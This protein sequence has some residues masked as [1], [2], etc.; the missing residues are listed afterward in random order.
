MFLG[1]NDPGAENAFVTSQPDTLAR[2]YEL[3]HALEMHRMD[4]GAMGSVRSTAEEGVTDRN[5]ESLVTGTL[6]FG[7]TARVAPS[8]PLAV[9]VKR[10]ESMEKEINSVGKEQFTSYENGNDMAPYHEPRNSPE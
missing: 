2:F 7:S 8:N 5:S 6:G 4:R 10:M 9:I 1:L 3:L